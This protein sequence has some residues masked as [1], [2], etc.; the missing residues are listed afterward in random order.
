MRANS[1]IRF[2]LKSYDATQS[3]CECK[4]SM[5]L[6]ASRESQSISCHSRRFFCDLHCGAVI[7]TPAQRE[8]VLPDYIPCFRL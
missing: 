3:T 2:A 5:L 6:E 7:Y 8:F 4:G 1:D